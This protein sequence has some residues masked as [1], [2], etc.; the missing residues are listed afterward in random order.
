MI[1]DVLRIRFVTLVSELM[2]PFTYNSPYFLNTFSL[3]K[4]L[5]KA[6]LSLL[7]VLLPQGSGR[8]RFSLVNATKFL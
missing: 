4:K 1:D 8:L 7:T 2:A 6:T 5:R 3:L